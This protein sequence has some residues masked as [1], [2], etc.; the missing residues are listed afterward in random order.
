MSPARGVPVRGAAIGVTRG[1][2]RVVVCGVLV[3]AV[4]LGASAC[5]GESGPVDDGTFSSLRAGAPDLLDE[6][7]VELVSS[8]TP[9]AA[10]AVQVAAALDRRGFDA[11]IAP[12]NSMDGVA[13]A[14]ERIAGLVGLV[15][16]GNARRGNGRFLVLAFADIES[17]VVFA[18]SGPE[19]FADADLESERMSYFSGNL[20]AYYAPVGDDDATDRFRGMLEVLAGG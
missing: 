9:A 3:V 13:L 14:P 15:G 10:S 8:D 20:V 7:G 5:S 4:G 17:A 16:D 6:A 1:V 2:A 11:E 12:E 19:V 18:V